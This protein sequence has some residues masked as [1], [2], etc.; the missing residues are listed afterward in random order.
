MV[1]DKMHAR[2][3]GPRAILTR[4]PTEGRSRDGGLRL[5][6]MER[7]CLIGYGASMLLLERLMISSDQFRWMSCASV[8]CWVTQD[9][10]FEV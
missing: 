9:G 6:E 2:A 10:K 8:A 1:L 4:Q 5:G 3:K 7:D